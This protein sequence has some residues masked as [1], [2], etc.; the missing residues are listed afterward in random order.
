[1]NYVFCP[2]EFLPS[3]FN[4]DLIKFQRL[5]YEQLNKKRKSSLSK[6]HQ[7]LTSPASFILKAGQI[8]TDSTDKD[9]KETINV[10]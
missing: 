10:K 7:K 5:T 8:V 3:G 2:P 1:M 4:G 9:Q 6:L